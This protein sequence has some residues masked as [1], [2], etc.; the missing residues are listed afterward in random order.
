MTGP[1]HVVD[2]DFR[3]HA[4]PRGGSAGKD[5]VP[6]GERGRAATAAKP[7][8]RRPG[9]VVRLRCRSAPGLTVSAAMTK[10]HPN[11]RWRVGLS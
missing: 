1:F 8:S 2:K 4:R 7:A 5:V 3:G 9:R 10:E 11:S 6:R